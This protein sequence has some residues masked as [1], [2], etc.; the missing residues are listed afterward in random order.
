MRFGSV[1]ALVVERVLDPVEGMHRAIAQPWITAAGLLADVAPAHDLML[2]SVYGSIRA[3]TSMLGAA[4]DNHV[5]AE[6]STADSAVAVL[7]GLWGDA[8]GRH[9]ER[10]DTPMTLLDRCRSAVT[11]DSSPIET[12]EPATGHL[13]LLVHGFAQ[14]E[15]C[16]HRAHGQRGLLDALAEQPD[17]TPLTVRYNSGRSID[18]NGAELSRLLEEIHCDWPVPVRSIALV[19]Y[20]MGGLVI[21]SA[22]RAG[23]DAGHAWIHD[24]H[25]VVSIGS[26]HRGAPLEKLV[27]AASLG[28]G[29]APQT[30]PL[31]EFL[32]TRS[33]GVQDLRHGEIVDHR[34]DAVELAAVLD[35]TSAAKI[36]WHFVAGVITSDPAHPFGAIVGDLVVRPASST[37]P[38]HLEPANVHVV[39][40]VH[41]LDLLHDAPVIDTI[42]EWLTADR[43]GRSH[44][45][46]LRST[47]P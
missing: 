22:F 39:G 12:T 28:L 19:G 41:H 21:N 38:R 44:T 46:P 34:H 13:A 2:R 42:V 43:H 20:S 7:N 3:G 14:N 33:Q 11:S 4:L 27:H 5:T 26:P 15:T 17:L 8:L 31:A 10:L 6:W 23:R 16:W 1:V 30:R 24:L 40:G 32:N 37:R 47:R 9:H 45:T 36:H 25:D 18:D 35:G 29:V